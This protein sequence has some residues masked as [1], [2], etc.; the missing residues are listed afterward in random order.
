[1]LHTASGVVYELKA[2]I[3]LYVLMAEVTR[4]HA[5]Q[6]VGLLFYFMQN[7]TRNM[8]LIRMTHCFASIFSSVMCQRRYRLGK[9]NA[10]FIVLLQL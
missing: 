5:R 9:Q 6:E 2:M 8:I 3:H 7:S 10:V 4:S 1:M